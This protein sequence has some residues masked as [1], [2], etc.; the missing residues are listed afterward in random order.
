MS[1]KASI[2]KEAF[3]A[4]CQVLIM[5]ALAILSQRMVCSCTYGDGGRDRSGNF[6]IDTTR[7]TDGR[8]M[9]IASSDGS[10]LFGQTIEFGGDDSMCS[11]VYGLRND[12]SICSC[13][14]D[15]SLRFINFRFGDDYAAAFGLSEEDGRLLSSSVTISGFNMKYNYSSSRSGSLV[16]IVSEALDTTFV[17]LDRGDD[18]LHISMTAKY[19]EKVWRQA[20]PLEPDYRIAEPRFDD[21]CR[22]DTTFYFLGGIKTLVQM[23]GKKRNGAYFEFDRSG[24]VVNVATYLDGKQEGPRFIFGKQ[25]VPKMAGYKSG[26]DWIGTVFTYHSNGAPKEL[27]TIG[28]DS[29]I[30]VW[31]Y[32]SSGEFIGQGDADG[33]ITR[34]SITMKS[35]KSF[36]HNKMAG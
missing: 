13:F 23:A 20:H 16:S 2:D 17:L 29:V 14:S 18:I 34:N 11:A 22:V 32:D 6:R 30:T 3:E 36:I 9:K 27:A 7:H 26:N 4:V 21:C 10:K 33:F 15:S 5:A 25:G 28:D 8:L 19:I 12:I 24:K 1:N 31:E 35:V